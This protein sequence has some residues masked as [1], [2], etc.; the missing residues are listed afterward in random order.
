MVQEATRPYYV[1]NPTFADLEGAKVYEADGVKMINLTPRQ[2]RYWIEQGAI[3]TVPEDKRSAE[4]RAALKQFAGKPVE[5]QGS[6]TP[7]SAPAPA[8]EAMKDEPK[9]K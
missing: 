4:A 5:E 8:P 6:R 7:L 9:K 2:A 3:S 1:M